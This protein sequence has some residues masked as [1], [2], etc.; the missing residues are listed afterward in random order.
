MPT[1]SIEVVVVI[2]EAEKQANNGIDKEPD[3]NVGYKKLS[4]HKNLSCHK[5]LD[6]IH[7]ML[8]SHKRFLVIK[9]IS[10]DILP[11]AMFLS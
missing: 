5:K 8:S 1:D 4:T 11:V 10:C 3:M 7:K 9:V 6:S 2:M